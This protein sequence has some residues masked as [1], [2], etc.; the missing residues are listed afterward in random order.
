MARTHA[1]RKGA[2]MLME[3][4]Q[5]NNLIDY[6]KAVAVVLVIVN[7]TLTDAERD[8]WPYFFI[9][10]MA[11]PI[12]VLISG[13]NYTASMERRK[14]PF[15]WYRGKRLLRKLVTYL[16]PMFAVFLVWCVKEAVGGSLDVWTLVK[17]FV[18]QSY[19]FGAYYFWIA[20]QLYLMF[21]AVYVIVRRKCGG[22]LDHP[23][24][25]CCLRA[26]PVFC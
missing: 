20:V 22:V 14:S 21:P 23:P 1:D 24:Y 8:T 13:F 18:L 4:K 15:D 7:H 19:G 16:A 10:R 9:V 3:E 25:Q 17:S 26:G 12:F 6:L 11:V 2:A 5:R